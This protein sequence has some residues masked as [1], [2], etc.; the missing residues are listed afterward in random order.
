[1]DLVLTTEDGVSVH[2][3]VLEH[4][5]WENLVSNVDDLAEH[6]CRDCGHKAFEDPG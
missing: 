1:V 2:R 3:I 4:V 6:T 5:V